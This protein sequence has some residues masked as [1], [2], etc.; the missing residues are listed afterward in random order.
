MQLQIISNKVMEVGKD[1]Q[2]G[3]FLRAAKA[4][5]LR[6]G[7]PRNGLASQPQ[8]TVAVRSLWLDLHA[9]TRAIVEEAFG[10]SRPGLSGGGRLHG[11][12][13]LGD[14][15]RRRVPVRLRAAGGGGPLQQDGAPAAGAVRT[16][17]YCP[18]APARAGPPP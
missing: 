7:L 6:S 18:P 11:S 1:R 3:R 8:R 12:R 13:Q 2:H 4:F 14:L 10:V 17:P 9:A 5:I 15:A 16:S